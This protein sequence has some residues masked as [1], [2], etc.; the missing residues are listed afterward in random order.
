LF[1]PGTVRTGIDLGTGTVKL[2]R[3][4]GDS[5]LRV[6]T[7]LGLEDWDPAGSGDDVSRASGALR[8]LL[9]RLGLARGKLGRI[10]TAVPGEESSIREVIMPPL[11]EAELRRALP[12]EARN[13]LTLDIMSDPVLDCQVL[14]P[15][16]AA[17]PDGPEQVR[18]L[19]AAVPRERRDFPL[20]VLARLGLEPEVVDL[21]PMASLNALLGAAR[22]IPPEQP[23]A[24]LDLGGRQAVLH[25]TRCAGGFLSRPVGPGVPSGAGDA[26]WSTY[27]DELATWIRETM[28][29]YRGRYRQEVGSIHLAGGGALRPGLPDRLS[30]G[31]DQL[32]SLLDPS[33]GLKVEVG[34]EV[35]AAGAPRFVTAC[36][37]CRWWDNV[38]V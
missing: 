22:S 1:G 26:T 5:C 27:A 30:Q 10:A 14:G 34:G 13:H 8:R 4:E 21:E 24:V 28:T 7:H 12:F 19:L 33:L 29:F 18:V 31:I 32:V 2:A 3:G 25:I 36:G 20:Q 17:E 38:D 6:I 11:T 37:L 15:A 23:L 35:A 16:P 9:S